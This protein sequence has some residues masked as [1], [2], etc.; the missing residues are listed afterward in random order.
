MGFSINSLFD[1]ADKFLSAAYLKR[2]PWVTSELA[3]SVSGAPNQSKPCESNLEE[4]Q[5]T[6]AVNL[7]EPNDTVLKQGFKRVCLETEKGHLPCLKIAANPTKIL[8]LYRDLMNVLGD[9]VQVVLESSH[10]SDDGHTDFYASAD[11]IALKSATYDFEDLLLNDSN[12]GISVFETTEI[13]MNGEV[14]EEHREV[15]LSGKKV[16]FV[17]SNDLEPFERILRSYGIKEDEN[18]GF[19]DE[20][21]DE[22]LD[23]HSKRY[24]FDQFDELKQRLNAESVR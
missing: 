11:A 4:L 23:T 1:A 13:P 21:P 3:R 14:N 12:T 7:R 20:F 2:N 6:G 19:I 8:D 9:D 17:Y 16:I 10:R 24:H 18:M 15:K 5:L 22:E